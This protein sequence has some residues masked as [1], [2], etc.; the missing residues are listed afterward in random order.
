MT[1]AV[2]FFEIHVIEDKIHEL[3]LADAGGV[4][5]FEDDPIPITDMRSK[6]PALQS[7]CAPPG[8]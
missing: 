4:K 7:P 8:A 2:S 5:H 1:S 3:E 6:C